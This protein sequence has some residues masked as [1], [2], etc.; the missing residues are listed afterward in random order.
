[1]FDKVNYFAVMLSHYGESIAYAL[2]IGLVLV[3]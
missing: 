3:M 2:M 1:M